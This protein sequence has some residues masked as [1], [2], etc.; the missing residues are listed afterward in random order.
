MSCVKKSSSTGL[1]MTVRKK[2]KLV[3]IVDEDVAKLL[4]NK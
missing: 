1:R 4:L 3:A 2:N